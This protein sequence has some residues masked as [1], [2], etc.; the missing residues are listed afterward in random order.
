[1]FFWTSDSGC[2]MTADGTGYN[3][4]E[5][6][7]GGSHCD[8]DCSGVRDA[9]WDLH[10][11]HTPDTPLNFVCSACSSSS[12]PC[13][14]QVHCA[15]APPRQAAWDFVVRDLQSAPFNLD[16]QTAFIVGNKVF[17]QGSGNVGS[18]YT[19][20]CGSSSG[21]CGATNGYMQWLAADDDDGNISNGTPHMTALYN[22]WNRHEIA[23]ATPSPV[24]SGCA[25][26][27]MET[28]D[29]PIVTATSGDS[30]I[31]ISWGGPAVPA[32]SKYWVFRTEGHAGCDFNKALIAETTGLSYTDTEVAN[33]RE[34]YYNVVAVD[35]S[36]ACFSRVSN[37]AT[38]TPVGAPDLSV[39]CTLASHTLQQGA[40]GSS[41]CT[42]S[43]EYGWSGN[44][45]LTCS[46]NPAGI[47]C[48]FAPSSVTVP[49]DGSADSTLTL[50]VDLAQ[51]T[52]SYSF[53]VVATSGAETRTTGMGVLV[54][55]EGTNGPQDAVYNATYQA[56]ACLIP[57][58][59]C[60]SLALVDGRD[61][62]GPEPNQPNTIGGTCADG[63]SGTYHSDES[64]DRIV[65]KTLDGTDFF[66]G[67]TVEI[68]A[69]V[70]AWST[71]SSDALDLY[72]AAD[73]N[74]PAWVYI[75]S[76]VPSAGGA[77]MLS[78]TYTLPNGG[79]QA[80]R[81][82]FRYS[83]SVGSCTTGGYDDRDDLVFAVNTG[84]CAC[85]S[86]PDCDDGL[87][88]NGAETC[89]GCSCQA[90]TDPCF[91]D[92]CDEVNDVCVAGC[93]QRKDP[94]TTDADCCAGLSCHPKKLWCR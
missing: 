42:V 79:L 67:A 13:G 50:T 35:T 76:I 51:A 84:G 86:D 64:N 82:N 90:G 43:A 60:D 15:A 59:E 18:W 20:S 32:A 40:N 11:D 36:D 17:Y 92:P 69:T 85:V 66:E 73:A 55:P 34:Y 5:N 45:D 83:D 49:V 74:S 14:A 10:A 91:P 37:C 27:A 58:S 52:G 24:T 57:G 25:G 71:G 30:Q 46:G 31:S 61:G 12:G 87:W 21:G 62:V 16:N 81:A 56:P 78:T 63:T 48:G 53:D 28:A 77:Q 38:A 70:W 47:A 2:G 39:S 29:P 8:L 88:C 26:R 68:E 44:A 41:T 93:G 72:Y 22:A 7:T 3:Q 65:V 6:Q 23:C 80:V 1:G 33:G 54:V 89:D 94:C 9:D 4:N 75:T 19:C